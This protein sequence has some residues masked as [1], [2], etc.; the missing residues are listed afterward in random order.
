MGEW[1][2]SLG[3]DVPRCD[4]R[5]CV[6]AA[7]GRVSEIHVAVELKPTLKQ[8]GQSG[9]QDISPAAHFVVGPPPSKLL[10]EL[11]HPLGKGQV[12]A[13]ETLRNQDDW[14]GPV[15]RGISLA[16]IEDRD[17]GDTRPVALS[18]RGLDLRLWKG[19]PQPL[20]KRRGG[21]SQRFAGLVLPSERHLTR[22]RVELE[23]P[24]E[25]SSRPVAR[26]VRVVDLND[27]EAEL[28]Q[29]ADRGLPSAEVAR[30][31]GPSEG[32]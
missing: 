23:E 2:T 8:G 21:G 12:D 1:A 25:P 27:V 11:G 30:F 29:L 5:R 28:S 32:C 4:H 31:Q 3:R 19:R 10:L 15:L 20:P 24:C 17:P 13:V 9:A 26:C 16:G 22:R 7:Q 14:V 6:I 18:H